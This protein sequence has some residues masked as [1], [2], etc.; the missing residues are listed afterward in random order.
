MN[1]NIMMLLLTPC[2]PRISCHSL[3]TFWH[4][5]L[6][7]KT[8]GKQDRISA[9]LALKHGPKSYDPVWN[10]LA[11]EDCRKIVGT[12]GLKELEMLEKPHF[13]GASGKLKAIDWEPDC[14]GS[15]R[16]FTSGKLR[17]QFFKAADVNPTAQENY[18]LGTRNMLVKAL[19]QNESN[20]TSFPKS[21][22]ATVDCSSGPVVVC[23]PPGMLVV[24][25]ALNSSMSCGVR[26]AFTPNGA[27]SLA[28]F[29]LAVAPNFSFKD[30]L[31]AAAE[32]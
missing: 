9:P 30:K 17:M 20:T 28:D 24:Q 21:L 15:L 3:D 25:E 6:A 27:N 10:L 11:P 8:K 32:A 22:R 31:I 19:N 5:A 18:Q 13:F 12:K 23:I 2:C 1:M 16:I 7:D 4:E 26:R 29:K 14:L